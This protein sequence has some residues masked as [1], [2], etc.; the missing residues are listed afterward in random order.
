MEKEMEKEKMETNRVKEKFYGEIK[1]I[2]YLQ[3]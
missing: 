2:T 3:K 1:C